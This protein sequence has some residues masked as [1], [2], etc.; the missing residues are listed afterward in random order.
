M[1][2][3]KKIKAQIIEYDKNNDA[4]VTWE[5]TDF[6]MEV[7]IS[8]VIIFAMDAHIKIYGLSKESMD[9][10]TVYQWNNFA[11]ENK[12][13]IKLF[14]DE[15]NGEKEIY[16]GQINV[17][18]PVYE[19]PNIYIDIQ[20]SAGTFQNTMGDIPPSSLK[21][22]VSV[23]DIFR[24]IAKDYGMKLTNKGV[25]DGEKYPTPYF[26][27]DGMKNRLIAASSA[28]HVKFLITS[29]SVII[30]PENSDVFYN[31]VWDIT[32]EDYIGYPSF[33]DAGIV[34]NFDTILDIDINDKINISGSDVEVANQSWNVN[35][36]AYNISTK[37]GGKWVMQVN[38]A[39]ING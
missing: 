39:R 29:D 7:S 23:P 14:V 31:R 28:Y 10:I 3:Q 1:F 6:P 9:A 15:G 5:W 13:D 33:N 26:D 24:K 20:A 37:I 18:K 25:T 2:V 34:L 4:V 36:I 16:S 35:R 32:K 22:E 21:E 38:G 17:A 8:K 27:Q 12:R 30:Y 19:Q 11:I